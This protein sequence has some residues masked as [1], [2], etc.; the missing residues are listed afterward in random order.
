VYFQDNFESWTTHGGAWSS[1]SGESSLHALNTSTDYAKAGAKSLK[2]TDTDTS[3]IYGACLVKN[4]SPAISGDI[5]VRFFVFFPT[6][7]GSTNTSCDRRLL[8]AYC[9]TNRAQISFLNGAPIMEEVGAWGA[10]TGSTISEGAWHCIEMHAATP[11]ASTLMELWVD[12]VKNSSTLNGAFG[13]STT[14]DYIQFGDV[15]LGGGTNGTGTFYLDELV[16]SNSYVG[17]GITSPVTYFSDNF[18]S[19][20]VHGGAWSSVNGESAT[21]TLNTS[22]DQARS[23]TKSL[24]LTDTD[25]TAT[26]GASLTKNFSPTIS[27]DIYVR[28]YLFFPTG[29]GSTNSGCRRRV[30]RVYCGSNR[31]QMSF[32]FQD[33]YPVMEEVGAWGSTTGSAISENAWHCVEMH[34]TA[35]TA[36]TVLEFWVDG[37]LHSPALMANFSASSTWDHIDLGDVALASGPNGTGTFYIDEAVVSNSYVGTLP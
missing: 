13:S 33:G 28:F 25:T 5:Y 4:F 7:Y 36:T 24:K 23:G 1:V 18:E 34:I 3:A 27:G 17:T 29:F 8:R 10:V 9:G 14:W 6:G 30:L 15:V 2:L 16:V 22:T 31:G 26:T 35:P 20:T 32:Q 12:G 37:V 19:W 11:S 21:H